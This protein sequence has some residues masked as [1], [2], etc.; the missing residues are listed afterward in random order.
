VNAI[1]C[2]VSARDPWMGLLVTC[3]L[4]VLV[5]VVSFILM[6]H[7]DARDRRIHDVFEDTRAQFMSAARRFQDSRVGCPSLVEIVFLG[8][9]ALQA[10]N[11]AQRCNPEL[12][13]DADWMNTMLWVE[14]KAKTMGLWRG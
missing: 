13:P 9:G 11:R 4:F 6:R 5:L 2:C 3:D 10:F 1:S 8:F 12:I 7:F 14:R